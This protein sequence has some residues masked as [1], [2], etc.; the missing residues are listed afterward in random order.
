[1]EQ[2]TLQDANVSKEPERRAMTARI[3]E[4]KLRLQKHVN[5]QTII[6]LCLLVCVVIANQYL[7]AAYAAWWSTVC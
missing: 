6:C 3:H 2:K 5:W 7:Y 4:K 1:M